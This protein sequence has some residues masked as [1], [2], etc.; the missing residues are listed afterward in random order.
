MKACA[1]ERER[2]ANSLVDEAVALLTDYNEHRGRRLMRLTELRAR[3]HA[4]ESA[5]FSDER[6][7]QEIASLKE[8]LD[9]KIQ[10]TPRSLEVIPADDLKPHAELFDDCRDTIAYLLDE[11]GLPPKVL[12]KVFYADFNSHPKDAM[13]RFSGRVYLARERYGKKNTT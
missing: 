1:Y 12:A 6:W 2:S 7:T 4:L 3:L 5:P 8:R 11:T 9:T 10:S 13:H